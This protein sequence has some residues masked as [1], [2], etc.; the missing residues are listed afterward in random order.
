MELWPY[1]IRV[2]T[3]DFADQLCS[4]YSDVVVLL[5]ERVA[6]VYRNIR[7]SDRVW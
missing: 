3:Y 5:Q 7:C 2:S 1:T 4:V 6:Q